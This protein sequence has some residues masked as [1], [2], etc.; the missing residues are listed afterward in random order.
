MPK[1]NKL[2][3]KDQKD[4]DF[5]LV[6]KKQLEEARTNSGMEVLWRQAD[7]DYL[8]H[9]LGKSKKKVLV[10]NERTE[11]SSYVSLEKD[12]WRSKEAKNDPYI[13]IQTALSIILDRNPE[14]VF[15]PGSKRFEANNIVIEKLYHRTWTDTNIGAKKELK[16]FIFNLSKYGWAPARRYYKRVVRKDM[17]AIEKYNL[18]TQEF[19]YKSK[20][21]VDVDDVFFEAFNPFNVWIDDMAKPDD[22]RRRDWMWREVY[23]ED[24]FYATFGEDKRAL[25]IQFSSIVQNDVNGQEQKKQYTSDK[26]VEV[27]FYENR[28][29]DKFLV[30]A[31]NKLVKVSPLMTE[32]KEMSLVDTYWTMRD[33]ESP[34]GIGLNEIMRNNKVMLDRIRNMTI[35]QVVLSIY[36]MFFYANSEQLDDEGGEQ[37]S[38]EPGKGK[39]VIDPKNITWMDV[40]GPGK[41]A[42]E[43]LEILRKDMEDDTGITRTLE[44]EITGK[45]AFEISQAQQGAL[46]RLKL[47]LSNIK[48]ALEWDAK[49]CVSLMKMIYSVPKVYSLIDP[50][51][52]AN[53]V[54][55]TDADGDRYY[56]DETGVFN[57]LKYREFQLSIEADPQGNFQASE[58]KKFFQVKP[59][60]LEWEGEITI[61]VDSMIEQSRPLERQAKL[62]LS[63]ILLPL[64][65]A[66]AQSPIM[67]N[68]YIRPVKQLLKIYDE[69]PTDWLP[70]EWLNGQPMQM[71]PQMGAEGMPIEAGQAEQVAPGM[72]AQPTEMAQMQSESQYAT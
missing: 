19:E 4:L 60:Y 20:E 57:A 56:T 70:E 72:E 23:D 51:L 26:L 3:K 58:D 10:E 66:M 59:K 21:M 27:F 52:I 2:N 30:M 29:K 37:I 32:N 8:P 53:Y 9:K 33:A 45:T 39:K 47:P 15:D 54:A 24:A 36:K 25:G 64:L 16:K 11:V 48:S 5:F 44:G 67:F 61:R 1:P 50:E 40:P 18:Q 42:Y 14:A 41:D 65:A 68:A 34:Y 55:S 62:E 7:A 12:Q 6:R 63:N 13:K 49:L 35:D 17:Q 43:L 69:N 22:P 71:Q 46:K 28:M 31:E 38:I